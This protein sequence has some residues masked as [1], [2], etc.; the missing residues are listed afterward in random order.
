MATDGSDHGKKNAL[1]AIFGLLPHQSNHRRVIAAGAIPLLKEQLK[2]CSREDI[3]SDCLA[4]LSCLA[5]NCEGAAVIL[6]T[7]VLCIVAG[8]LNSSTSR[9]GRE[10]CINLLL[11][12]CKNGGTGAVSHLAESTSLMTSLYSLLSE[13]TSRASKKAS[14]LIRILQDYSEKRSR[15]QPPHIF[16]QELYVPAW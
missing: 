2:S 4:V 16:L 13:G 12:I 8:I 3:A 15:N 5:E 11:N 9:V 7:G 14:S 6:R 10:N 1:V